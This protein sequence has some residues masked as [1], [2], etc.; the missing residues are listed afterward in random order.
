MKSDIILFIVFGLV[1]IIGTLMFLIHGGSGHKS[2]LT[3]VNHYVPPLIN[4]IL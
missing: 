2:D 1:N 4:N 3:L